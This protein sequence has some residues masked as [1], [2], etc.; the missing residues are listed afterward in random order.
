M[1]LLISIF[2][3]IVCGALIFINAQD[4]FTT[5]RSAQMELNAGDA[6]YKERRF[7]DAE[8]HFRS[9]L[10]LDPSEKRTKVFLAR[11]LHQLY[12]SNRQLP[13]N[14]QK[15]EEAIAF[16]QVLLVEDPNDEATNDALSGSIG[17]LKGSQALTE[18]RQKRADNEA[19][20][21]EYRV[22]AFTFL[23]SEKYNCV[24]E[25]T[26]A[27]KD[28]VLKKG[29]AVFVFKMV[30][31][32]S[33]FLTARQCADDGLILIDKALALDDTKSSPNSYKASLLIQKS[34]LAEMEGNK[35]DIVKYQTEAATFKRRFQ[36]L[37][38]QEAKRREEEEK[39]KPESP[40]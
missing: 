11:T 29:E 18:W 5:T 4:P 32:Y 15:G 12:L 34:R 38:E 40:Q 24:N 30:D 22:K 19:V 17:A 20:K 37:S 6:A 13:E 39:Q 28:T 3:L 7:S 21:P 25:V 31:N 9:A 35:S 27:G 8:A 1:K 26:E 23:A 14:R 2:I 10:Q 16:Y 36:A 33:D